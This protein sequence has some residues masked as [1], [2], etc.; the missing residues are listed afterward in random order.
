MNKIS[1]A[2][3]RQQIERAIEQERYK[4]AVAHARHI[5]GEYPK[6]LQAYWLMGKAMLKAG[7][8]ELAT[9]ML[10][11]VLSADP[12]HL[13]AW[14]GMSEIAQ[15][16]E[17]LEAAV[18]YLERAFELATDNE[19]VAEELR[20]LYGQLEGRQPERLQLTQGAL[21]RLYLRGDLLSRA[22]SEFRKLLQKHPDRIDLKVALAEALWRSGQRLQASEVCQDILEEQPYN[23]KANLILGEIWTDSGREEGERY[24]D[25]A[26]AVDP[27]NQVAQE[28]FGT[29][30]PLP[31]EDPQVAPLDYEAVKEEAPAWM[32]EV[33]ELELAEGALARPEDIATTTI[34][35]PE[36]LQDLA[37]GVPAEAPVP[38]EPTEEVTEEPETPEEKPEEPVA[39]EEEAAQEMP[40][41]EMAPEEAPPVEMAEEEMAEEPAFEWL[42]ELEEEEIEF[43]GA[44]EEAPVEEEEEGIPAW[45]TEL[46]LESSEEGMVAA[47]DLEELEEIE[48]AEEPERADIPDWLRDLAPA[49]EDRS[50]MPSADALAALLDEGIPDAEVPEEAEDLPAWLEG[51]EMPSGDDALAWL[52]ELTEGKEEELLAEAEADSDARLAEILGEPEEELEEPDPF[53]AWDAEE[54]ELEAEETG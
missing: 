25:R 32:A 36:W 3:Y 18:W 16:Q 1:L 10:E 22:I 15:Q 4:E 54:T 51:E 35:I 7:Q 13:L 8:D 29:T 44:E 53:E 26:E 48:E 23:L 49:E 50:D 12:E 46:G 38:A 40:R 27:E 20:R 42:S 30:S 41:E 33:E 9:D 2:E 39:T 28:L 21:A 14:V 31:P 17:D 37:P 43:A 6:C 11:R 52:E 5:L 45:L 19:M 34:E 24:L 47:E